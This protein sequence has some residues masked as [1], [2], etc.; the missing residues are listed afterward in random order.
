ML[1]YHLS[2]ALQKLAEDCEALVK[3]LDVVRTEKIALERSLVERHTNLDTIINEQNQINQSMIEKD[4][5]LALFEVGRGAC[6]SVPSM[7]SQR[8]SFLKMPFGGH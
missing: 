1:I 7:P 8:S 4:K 5:A 6:M 3:E 2:P